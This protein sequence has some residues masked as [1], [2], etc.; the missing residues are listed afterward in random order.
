MNFLF[1][2]NIH[3]H[4]EYETE[5]GNERRSL[6]YFLPVDKRTV[7]MANEVQ[8]QAI[9]QMVTQLLAEDPDCFL[10]EIR[11]KP[12]NNVKVFLDAD[13]GISIAKCVTY[14]R[15]LYKMMEESALYP[16]GDFSLEVSSPGLSEPLKLLRQYRKNI[17]RN[18][19]VVLKDGTQKEGK[20]T[21]VTEE[22]IVVEEEKGKNKKKEVVSHALLFEHI[23]Q[24]K[25]QIVF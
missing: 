13:S 9:E 18:V 3:L 15:A 11:I 17:G 25:I 19:E 12:T 20:L 24:T 2:K 4:S 8:I 23:K 10:V 21:E 5:E 1:K 14:N 22:G 7:F 16:D 6:L